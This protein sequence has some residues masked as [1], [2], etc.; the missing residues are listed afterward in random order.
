MNLNE[1]IKFQKQLSQTFN[2]NV[3]AKLQISN[4]IGAAFITN[5]INLIQSCNLANQAL[6]A[7]EPM[8]L[9][10]KYNKNIHKAFSQNIFT[11]TKAQQNLI[12][13]ISTMDSSILSKKISFESSTKLAEIYSH[14]INEFD[15][16][17]HPERM[18]E[19]EETV[20]ESSP[21]KLSLTW[22]QVLN[23]ILFIITVITF[24]QAQMPN[25][26]L[27]TIESSLQQLIEIQTKELDL[28]KQ[29]S[30]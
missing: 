23:I 25:K 3:L 8:Q 13:K 5:N 17:V 18:T 10:I 19:P 26:Q 15:I 29:L 2:L 22:A 11:F 1:Y 6:K 30:E 9:A 21:E 16:E 20:L 14:T 28:L 7:L 24:I 4:S 12:E 27:T